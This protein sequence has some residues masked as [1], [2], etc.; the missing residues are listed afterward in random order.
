M[1]AE[2]IDIRDFEDA[3]EDELNNKGDTELVVEFLA[4]N[5]DQAWKASAIAERTGVNPDSISTI[6]SRLKQRELVRHKEPYWAIT[7]DKQRLENAYQLHKQTER[8]D[9]K[10]GEESAEDWPPM[11]K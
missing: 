10:Y 3:N 1:G 5:G 6:L 7:D 8:L 11:E 4:Q 2:H 9:D